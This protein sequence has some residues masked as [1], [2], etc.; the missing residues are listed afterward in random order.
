MDLSIKEV[1]NNINENWFLPAIQRPYVWGSRYDEEKYICRLFD[2]I[3]K[4]ISYWSAYSLEPRETC[5][6]QK[7]Y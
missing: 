7:V 4:E 5:C 6:I 1:V 2:S 3:F